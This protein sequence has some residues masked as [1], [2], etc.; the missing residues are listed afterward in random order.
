MADA[1][2]SLT[3]DEE[4]TIGGRRLPRRLVGAVVGALVAAAAAWA[5]MVV[6]RPE[7][8]A[9]HGSVAA[10]T[11]QR[12]HDEHIGSRPAGKAIRGFFLL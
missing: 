12:Y 4:L 3:A 11:A 1:G 7:I 10:A 5:L 2:T 9:G 6:A 8:A